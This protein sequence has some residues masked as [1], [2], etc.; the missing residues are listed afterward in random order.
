M[1]LL[2]KLEHLAAALRLALHRRGD[3]LL[4]PL[5]EMAHQLYVSLVSDY[6]VALLERRE[7]ARRHLVLVARTEADDVNHPF[8]AFASAL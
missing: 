8:A 7:R 1:P 5:E 6:N 2:R 3:K 4:A